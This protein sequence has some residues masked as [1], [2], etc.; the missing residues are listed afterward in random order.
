MVRKE[1]RASAATSVTRDA[2]IAV[3]GVPEPPDRRC[4]LSKMQQALSWLSQQNRREAHALS[5]A[6]VSLNNRHLLLMVLEAGN[7]RCRVDKVT[8]F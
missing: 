1:N 5:R 3:C 2:E 8:F 7:P 6:P 4:P